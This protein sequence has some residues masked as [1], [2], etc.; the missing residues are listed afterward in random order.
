[1]A[2]LDRL[3]DEK[4]LAQVAAVIG[5]VF[6]RAFV[7]ELA[8]LPDERALDEGLHRLEQAAAHRHA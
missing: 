7:R 4:R 8:E 3:G 1:M 6:S 2:R 5:R